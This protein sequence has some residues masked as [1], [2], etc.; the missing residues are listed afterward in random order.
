MRGRLEIEQLTQLRNKKIRIDHL[1]ALVAKSVGGAH[2]GT[3]EYRKTS[4]PGTSRLLLLP[5]SGKALAS[6]D[7][8]LQLWFQYK[9]YYVYLLKYRGCTTPGL[10]YWKAIAGNGKK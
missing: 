9:L 2:Q 4:P 5:T 7:E 10:R 3:Q 1:H 6:A 8:I